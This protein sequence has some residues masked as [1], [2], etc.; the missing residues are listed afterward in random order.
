MVPVISVPSEVNAV[1]P[2]N[3]SSLVAVVWVVVVGL[4]TTLPVPS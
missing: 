3:I 1:L 2:Y 4:Y